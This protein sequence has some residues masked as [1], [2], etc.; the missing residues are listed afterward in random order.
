M[1]RYIRRH[2]VENFARRLVSVND[3]SQ[4]QMLLAEERQKQKDAGDFV[5]APKDVS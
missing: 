1:D 5:I 2:N 4:R 3:E